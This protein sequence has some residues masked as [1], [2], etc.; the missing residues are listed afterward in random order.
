MADG[1]DLT[2]PEKKNLAANKAKQFEAIHSLLIPVNREILLL[3]NA[4]VAEIVPYQ[5]PETAESAPEW[6]LGYIS[7]RDRRLPMISFELASGV[8]PGKIH[9]NCRIAILNTLNG[10]NQLPYIAVLMQGLP[11]LQVVKPDSVQI[12]QA[13]ESR[14]S[15]K[16]CVRVNGTDALIPDLD[17]L[18]S[19]ITRLHA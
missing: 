15:V 3:P 4:A 6:F 1:K 18:E 12:D 10:S 9:K 5:Q 17:D 16:A 2:Q 13:Q 14:N 7:W 11:S 8:E 19:R